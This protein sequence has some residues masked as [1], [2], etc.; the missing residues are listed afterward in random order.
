LRIS[1][2]KE[3]APYIIDYHVNI[4]KRAKEHL[5][6][7]PKFGDTISLTFHD[8]TRDQFAKLLDDALAKKQWLVKIKTE[9]Q[10]KEAM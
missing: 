7:V 10:K 6:P 3:H 1:Q 5:P 9:S 8:K 2:K 4:C